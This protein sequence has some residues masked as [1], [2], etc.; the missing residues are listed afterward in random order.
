MEPRGAIEEVPSC[1]KLGLAFSVKLECG[2]R[3]EHCRLNLA[4][5]NGS[6]HCEVEI[7]ANDGEQYG[8]VERKGARYQRI[9]R[10]KK[11]SLLDHP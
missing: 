11:S 10:G 3:V 5:S 7:E 4:S 2:R 8:C 1:P 6:L 9:L